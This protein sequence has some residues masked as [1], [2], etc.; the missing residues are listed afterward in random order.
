MLTAAG[1]VGYLLRHAFATNL[2][3]AGVDSKLLQQFAGHADRRSTDRDM[4][5]RNPSEE[6]S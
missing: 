5:L 4:S 3:R 1:G 6:A 2:L